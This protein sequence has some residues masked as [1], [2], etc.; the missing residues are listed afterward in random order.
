MNGNGKERTVDRIRK[1]LALAT[2]PNENEAA[3][4][5]EKAQA[6]LAE[7]NLSMADVIDT[8][9]DDADTQ[10]VTDASGETLSQPW[11]RPL[12]SAVA[13]L[14]F[15]KYLF[16][17]QNGKDR[18]MF[19]GAKLNITV[20]MMTFEYLHMTVDRLARQ[21]ARGLPKHEQ[22][23]YRISFRAAAARRLC[24]RLY[25]RLED[26]RNKCTQ[27]PTGTTLPA[28]ASLYDRAKAANQAFIDKQYGTGLKSRTSRLSDIHE[29]GTRDGDHAG[30]NIG[31]D[32]QVMDQGAP[33]LR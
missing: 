30:C 1:L 3:A 26:S 23:P 10:V 15:C 5:A 7:Y 25:E 18:H 16:V 6:L 29:G 14:F 28:L 13:E 17:T 33:L 31:L 11:R 24:W 20:A 9:D 4:A 32:P 27:T 21:G 19:V 8:A 22:S 2:S 12:A